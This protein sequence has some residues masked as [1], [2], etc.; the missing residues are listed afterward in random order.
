MGVSMLWAARA[1]YA[2]GNRRDGKFLILFGSTAFAMSG[3]L[4]LLPVL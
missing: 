4:A 3:I 2:D 1:D